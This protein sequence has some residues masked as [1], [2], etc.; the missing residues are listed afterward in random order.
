LIRQLSHLRVPVEASGFAPPPRDGFALYGLV[1]VIDLG[2][3]DLQRGP[4][5]H[6]PIG[7]TSRLRKG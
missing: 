3:V 2:Y 1:R 6:T 5:G 7:R 4:I